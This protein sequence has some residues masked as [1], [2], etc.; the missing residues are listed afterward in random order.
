MHVRRARDRVKKKKEEGKKNRPIDYE[1]IL[2]AWMDEND[3][4]YHD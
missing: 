4:K 1:Y 3:D 2:W